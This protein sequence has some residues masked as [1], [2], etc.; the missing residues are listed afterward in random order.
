M[1]HPDSRWTQ[2]VRRDSGMASG[3]AHSEIT[4]T[5]HSAVDPDLFLI[6]LATLLKDSSLSPMDKADTLKAGAEL[7]TELQNGQ[8]I[9]EERIKDALQN[10]GDLMVPIDKKTLPS[11]AKLLT[12]AMEAAC[13]KEAIGAKAS[14]A[15]GQH[16]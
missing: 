7:Y 8:G 2:F 4:N 12:T 3:N 1:T 9:S 13:R 5:Q 16:R 10:P 6:N 11:A 15:N 14:A